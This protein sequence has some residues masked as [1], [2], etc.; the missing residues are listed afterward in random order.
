MRFKA[1]FRDADSPVH[2]RSYCQR[3]S[4]IFR[5]FAAMS[6]GCN[7]NGAGV[8]Y[9]EF[10]ASARVDA[11]TVLTEA[12]PLCRLDRGK[13]V[14][15]PIRERSCDLIKQGKSENDVLAARATLDYDG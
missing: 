2:E 4:S 10:R 5:H 13:N 6:L 7:V 1:A 15:A 9:G 14:V 11:R 3:F 12:R 8:C